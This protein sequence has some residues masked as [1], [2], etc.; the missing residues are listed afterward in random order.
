MSD[1]A[2]SMADAAAGGETA[3]PANANASMSAG[4]KLPAATL[5]TPN[6]GNFSRN[7]IVVV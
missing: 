4:N 3:A 6:R 1:E 5:K 2:E 7:R